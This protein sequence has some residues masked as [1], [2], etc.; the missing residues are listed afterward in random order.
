M[1][2]VIETIP[3]Y[4]IRMRVRDLSKHGYDGGLRTTQEVAEYFGVPTGKMR[5]ILND[6]EDRGL[7]TGWERCDLSPGRPYLWSSLREEDEDPD[8]DDG[9]PI[10]IND[11]D[12]ENQV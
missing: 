12:E 5:K 6:L 11:N 4:L 7:I 8:P 1:L 10:P 3:D 2:T 9:E